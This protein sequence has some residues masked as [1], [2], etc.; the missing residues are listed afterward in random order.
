MTYVNAGST[1]IG[2]VTLAVTMLTAGFCDDAVA[3]V[4]RGHRHNHSAAYESNAQLVSP[5]PAQ[6]GQMRYYGGPKSPMW[7][8]VE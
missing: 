5:P 6:P 1:R 8:E 2:L 4:H 7:R 3:K